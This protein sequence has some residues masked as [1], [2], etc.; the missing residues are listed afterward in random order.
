MTASRG[1]RK[2]TKWKAV[3]AQQA[4]H[5]LEALRAADEQRESA[6]RWEGQARRY[7]RLA[8]AGVAVALVEAVLLV[9]Q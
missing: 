4:T 3:A 8:V 5:T 1:I 9:V 6:R 7:R 2:S